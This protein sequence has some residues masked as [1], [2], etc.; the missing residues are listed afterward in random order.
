M[1][2]KT[3]TEGV[4]RVKT[5]KTLQTLSKVGKILS[6]IVF[7][8]CIVGGVGCI[9][10]ILLLASVPN[11]LDGFKIGAVTIKGMIEKESGVSLMTCYAAMA[12]GVV[13]CAGEAV[14]A[15]FAQRYFKNELDAGTPFT[16]DGAKELIRLG[17]LT[18]CIPIGTM[19]VAAIVYAIFKAISKDVS[20]L[21]LHGSVSLGLG[22]M[23][24]I[25]GLLCRHGAEVSEK[26]E[27]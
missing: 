25:A 12:T 13:M 19:I 23:M 17:I 20:D 24:L 5:L 9:I 21:D 18:I 14:L 27:E 26:P 4:V 22:I 11:L 8:L 7:V 1:I 10:G 15:K 3:K 16:F 6:T 2:T